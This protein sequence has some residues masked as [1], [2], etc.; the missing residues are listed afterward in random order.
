MGI[1]SSKNPTILYNEIRIILIN[2]INSK[3]RW[4]TNKNNCMKLQL[5]YKDKLMNFDKDKLLG[6]FFSVGIPYDK[7]YPYKKNEICDMIINHYSKR[8]KLF[9]YI[10]KKVE[11]TQRM[12]LGL[13]GPGCVG[14]NELKTFAI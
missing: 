6:L 4:W 9:L 10:L 14:V 13:Y 3:Y 7:S 2:L 5:L 8:L 1:G 12:L 11:L